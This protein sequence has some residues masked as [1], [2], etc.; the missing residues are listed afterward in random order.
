[1]FLFEHIAERSLVLDG[2]VDALHQC[3]LE[4]DSGTWDAD[5]FLLPREVVVAMGKAAPAAVWKYVFQTTHA[6]QHNYE[7]GGRLT[8]HAHPNLCRLYCDRH[9]DFHEICTVSANA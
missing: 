1:M 9:G 4:P 6:S 3:R 2:C 7:K 8:A 5:G